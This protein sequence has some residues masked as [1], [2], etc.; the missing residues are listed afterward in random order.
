MTDPI[1]RLMEKASI[2]KGKR[3][4][5]GYVPKYFC[6]QLALGTVN[7]TQIDD[8]W[9]P[10]AAAYSPRLSRLLSPARSGNYTAMHDP[11]WSR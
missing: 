5:T 4:L 1:P 10:D 3:H 7:P 8:I 6:L 2:K 9:D 11:M